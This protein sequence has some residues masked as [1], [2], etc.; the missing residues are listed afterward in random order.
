MVS[1]RNDSRLEHYSGVDEKPAGGSPQLPIPRREDSN[2]L[3]RVPALDTE[4]KRLTPFPGIV[5]PG[6][7]DLGCTSARAKRPFKKDQ[8]YNRDINKQIAEF[9]PPLP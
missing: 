6:G 1:S 4:G 5:N 9:I 8:T 2:H 3:S 7:S